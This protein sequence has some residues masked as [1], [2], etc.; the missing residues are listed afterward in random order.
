MYTS[1]DI[2]SG[3]HNIEVLTSEVMCGI[4]DQDSTLSTLNVEK[5]H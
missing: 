3:Y 4:E 1:C 2:T 5:S